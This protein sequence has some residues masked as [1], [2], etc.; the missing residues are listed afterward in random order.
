MSSKD[1]GYCFGT[2]VDH[3]GCEHDIEIANLRAALERIRDCDWPGPTPLVYSRAD[4]MQQVAK[5]ALE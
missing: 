5:E 4:W 1:C 2:G 3:G